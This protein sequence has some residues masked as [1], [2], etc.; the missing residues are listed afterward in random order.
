LVLFV[1]SVISDAH[2]QQIVGI[3]F[4]L[5]VAVHDR[6]FLLRKKQLSLLDKPKTK[7]FTKPTTNE[8]TNKNWNVKI[9][10]IGIA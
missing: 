4:H 7:S 10:K 1:I 6:F 2:K 9:K 8:Q 5:V 3:L